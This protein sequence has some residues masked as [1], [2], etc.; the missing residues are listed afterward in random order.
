MSK[1][2]SS[3]L[4]EDYINSVTPSSAEESLPSSRL[5]STP[6]LSSSGDESTIAVSIPNQRQVTPPIGAVNAIH[7]DRPALTSIEC[8]QHPYVF[9]PIKAARTNQELEEE[10]LKIFAKT[11][12]KPLKLSKEKEVTFA[13]QSKIHACNDTS[14]DDSASQLQN[15]RL[16]KLDQ[17][18][19]PSKHR[20]RQRQRKPRKPEQQSPFGSSS[21]SLDSD[22]SLDIPPLL[23]VRY[24]VCLMRA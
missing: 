18:G 1:E 3:G 4:S 10:T 21:G 24:M 14:S 23:P 2:D 22:K 7:R 6:S 20:P 17:A 9:R 11:Y 19:K 12:P 5:P 15:P 13:K 16:K 8:E